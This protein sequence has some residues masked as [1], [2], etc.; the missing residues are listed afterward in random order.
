[1][2]RA[3]AKKKKLKKLKES[4]RTKNQLIILNE[5]DNVSQVELFYFKFIFQDFVSNRYFS[6]LSKLKCCIRF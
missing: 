2:P 5:N 4:S 1:M 6:S 3:N